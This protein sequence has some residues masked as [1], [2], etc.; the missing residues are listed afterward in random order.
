MDPSISQP[1]M[2]LDGY[3][4][5]V[6]GKCSVESLK[7]SSFWKH[8]KWTVLQLHKK[9]H[10][11]NDFQTRDVVSDRGNNTKGCIVARQRVLKG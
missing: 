8:I 2:V 6:V 10:H 3:W 9:Q 4:K 5:G 11:D 7:L 1:D